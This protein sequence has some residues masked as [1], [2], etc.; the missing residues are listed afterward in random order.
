MYLDLIDVNIETYIGFLLSYLM[1][2]YADF[3]VA[4]P[5]PVTLHCRCTDRSLQDANYAA[6]S[7]VQYFT[8]SILLKDMFVTF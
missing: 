5:R 8:G 7:F 4:R 1:L 2:I 3:C 6:H